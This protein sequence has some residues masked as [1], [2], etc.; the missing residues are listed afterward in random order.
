MGDVR[1]RARDTGVEIVANRRF[2]WTGWLELA[3]EPVDEV[4]TNMTA[5]V[6]L[7]VNADLLSRT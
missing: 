2:D 1:R 7:D 5:Q 6:F 3:K 4:T